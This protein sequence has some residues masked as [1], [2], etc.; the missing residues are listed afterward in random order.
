MT[1][2]DGVVG[3]LGLG[4]NEGDSRQQIEQAVTDIGLLPGTRVVRVSPF[5]G[6]T[7]WGKADQ[8][9]F[10][11]V[12]AEI[13]TE[14]EPRA[15]LDAVKAIER[16]HGR[17]PRERWGPRP[18]DID[19][20]VLGNRRVSEPGLEVPHPRMWERAFVLRPLADLRPTMTV[21]DGRTV[22][23][24]LNDADIKSQAIWLLT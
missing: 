17:G 6:S 16:A 22:I 8:P 24:R 21:P 11:N 9:D 20:L 14:L 1:R 7:P 12:V 13:A 23:E 19:I 18:L 4:S 2:H 3:Y 15:L 10:V 5:Y